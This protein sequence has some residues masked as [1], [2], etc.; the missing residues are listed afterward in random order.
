M[1]SMY[2]SFGLF[3]MSISYFFADHVNTDEQPFYNESMEKVIEPQSKPTKGTQK[4]KELQQFSKK[5][6]IILQTVNDIEYKAALTVMKPPTA[7]FTKPVIFPKPNMIAGKIGGK[8]TVLLKAGAGRVVGD[9]VESAKKTYTNARFVIGVGVCYAFKQKDRKKQCKLGD[10]LVSGAIRDNRYMKFEDGKVKDLGQKVD[11]VFELCE[12]FCMEKVKELDFDVSNKGR[13]SKMHC[14]TF[15]CNVFLIKDEKV[16]DAFR[17]ANA[18]DNLVGGEMEGGELLKLQLDRKVEGVIVIKGVADFADKKKA[19]DWQF[20]A[21]K[22]AL[23][24]IEV[25]LENTDD[26]EVTGECSALTSH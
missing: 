10:V 12:I 7:S 13:E 16:R 25:Q 18:D 9:Y 11:T 6:V 17:N 1:A 8:K 20:T 21:T 14:G 2:T 22:A 3:I 4:Y 24:Y 23:H 15:C 26:L 19:K 5:V